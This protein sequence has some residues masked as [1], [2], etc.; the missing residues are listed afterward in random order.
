[1][2]CLKMALS[3]LRIKKMIKFQEISLINYE[4]RRYT[5]NRENVDI[6]FW[7]EGSYMFWEVV[8]LLKV[9]E[10]QKSFG[11][12]TFISNQLYKSEKVTS[13]RRR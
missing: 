4:L 11:M 6:I 3:T 2:M 7:A 10:S 12:F 8:N 1:M 13:E 9:N 5:N